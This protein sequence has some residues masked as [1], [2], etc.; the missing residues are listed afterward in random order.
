MKFKDF[1]WKIRSA[2]SNF[3]GHIR[4]NSRNYEPLTG[5]HL[6]REWRGP[7]DTLSDYSYW[8]RNWGNLVKL[9]GKAPVEV[10]TAVIRYRWMWSLLQSLGSLENSK[11]GLR[12]T[13]LKVSNMNYNTV[14]QSLAENLGTLLTIDSDKAIYFD[15]NQINMI[16]RGIEGHEPVAPNILGVY[17]PSAVDQKICQIYID[18]T[19]TYGV[20]A[21]V[22]PLPS[23]EAGCA[24]EDDMIVKGVCGI[25]TNMPC[26][27]SIMASSIVGRRLNMPLYPITSPMRYNNED[28]MDYM[29]ED[30]KDCIKFLEKHTG[31][32]Y[33]FERLKPYLELANRQNELLEEKF[34]INKSDTPMFFG[35]QQWL[36]RVYQFSAIGLGE[37]RFLEN[38]EKTLKLMQKAVAKGEKIHPQ[39]RYRAIIWSTP[40]NYYGHLQTWLL[41][42]WGIVTVFSMLGD[43]GT[44]EEEPLNTED[45]MLRCI[46]KNTV[47]ATMRKQ[48]NGG[49]ENIIEELWDRCEEYKPD[50]VFLHDQVACKGMAGIITMFEEQADERD[51]KLCTMPQELLDPRTISRRDMREKINNFMFNVMKAEPLD[52]LLVDFDDTQGF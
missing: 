44:L 34:Q 19:E 41:N 3:D 13:A 10:S 21:D 47:R 35:M 52:P 8:L 1:N 15:N 49:H 24:I 32:T 14:V 42:C 48:T 7:K 16:L 11:E 2:M 27:G 12:G 25:E 40:C 22:C 26:D 45:D 50:I 17:I 20:P 31:E 46:A 4:G 9:A 28:A 29:V 23:A 38:D 39:Q 51:M 6:K 30:L 18:T 33:S 37:K 36:Y 5:H 43:S